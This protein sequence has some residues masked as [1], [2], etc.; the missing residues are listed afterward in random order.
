MPSA[1]FSYPAEVPPDTGTRNAVQPD[2][3][4]LRRMGE[5][6]ACFRYE[7]DVPPGLRRMLDHLLLPLLTGRLRGRP[8]DGNT[9]TGAPSFS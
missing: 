3:P 6:S 1:C 9:R 7:A 4:G 8:L 2:P 5:T